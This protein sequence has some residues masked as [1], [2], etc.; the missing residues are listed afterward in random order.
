VLA[1][2]PTCITTKTDA[3]KSAGH[4]D[5]RVL[6]EDGSSLDA[7]TTMMSYLFTVSLPDFP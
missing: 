4:A 2:V 5:I 6:S 1:Y 3:G 7:A